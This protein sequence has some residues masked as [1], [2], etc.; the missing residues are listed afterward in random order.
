[1][2]AT[3]AQPARCCE[4]GTHRTVKKCP[5]TH[6]CVLRN[7]RG[8]QRHRKATQARRRAPSQPCA[9]RA[10]ILDRP[11]RHP[12]RLESRC[13]P[14]AIQAARHAEVRSPCAHTRSLQAVSQCQLTLE[15]DQR[16]YHMATNLGASAWSIAGGRTAGAGAATAD[17][18]GTSVVPAPDVSSA[19]GG[20]LLRCASAACRSC[21]SCSA[22]AA[23]ANRSCSTLSAS[24]AAACSAA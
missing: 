16:A 17:G 6:Y 20:G 3:G 15:T 11:R 8:C 19:T 4:R 5:G 24:A 14:C 23:A 21:S 18:D 13:R 2:Y 7:A 10:A 12:P 1:M 9:A 22:A